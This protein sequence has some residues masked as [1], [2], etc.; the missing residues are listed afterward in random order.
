MEEF[1]K[2]LEKTQPIIDSHFEGYKDASLFSLL[3]LNSNLYVNEEFLRNYSP[4]FFSQKVSSLINENKL[5]QNVI[6]NEFQIVFSK[7]L[8]NVLL[9]MNSF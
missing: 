3:Y 2:T 1:S 6:G 8:K 5:P 7:L 9:N 4:F